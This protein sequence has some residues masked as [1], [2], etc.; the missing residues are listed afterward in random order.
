MSERNGEEFFNEG[1]YADALSDCPSDFEIN[2]SD[3][4]NDNLSEDG[5]ESD[6]K[7]PKEQIYKTCCVSLHMITIQFVTLK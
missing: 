1:L 6:I 4:E 3:S 7:P 5:Y 2:S